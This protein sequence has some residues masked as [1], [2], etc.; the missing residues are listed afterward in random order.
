MPWKRRKIEGHTHE[1][2]RAKQIG[3][4]LET[5]RKW[6]R[7]GKGQAYI[8][9]GREIFYIDADAPRWLA[10]MKKTPPRSRLAA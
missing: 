3:F 2:D 4:S 9:L 5:L 7:Q 10:S 8:T 1:R 6:R